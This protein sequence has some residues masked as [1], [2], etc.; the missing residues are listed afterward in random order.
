[1]NDQFITRSR[2]FLVA[3]TSLGVLMCAY[4]P[5]PSAPPTPAGQLSRQS[6]APDTDRQ[7]ASLESHNT[8]DHSTAAMA[9][10]AVAGGMMLLQQQEERAETYPAEGCEGNPAPF[11]KL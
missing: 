8:D 3:L 9:S 10:L 4:R 7:P 11:L 1:M 5:S 2:R 6:A